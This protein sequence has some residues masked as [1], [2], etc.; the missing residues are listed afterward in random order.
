M[1]RGISRRTRRGT[2]VAGHLPL[3]AQAAFTLIE[4]LV[5]IAIIA[6]LAA[7]LLPAL[8]QARAKAKSIQCL[9]GLRQM[10]IAAHVYVD[11]NA[12][13]YPVAQY[14]DDDA[15]NLY[16]WDLNVTYDD[17]GNA[18]VKPGI[19]WAGT[20]QRTNS[21][22]PVIRGRRGLGGQ[23]LHRLQLQHQ[24]PRPRRRRGHRAAG[25]NF[26]RACI[27]SKR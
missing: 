20:R 6:I 14:Y 12:D 11:D 22:M 5:V 23:S 27:R 9:S 17:N 13:F 19:L 8:A 15:G 16:C 2:P 10:G 18:T 21:T 25:Q 4:L 1:D 26:R 24:L 3:H 7:L